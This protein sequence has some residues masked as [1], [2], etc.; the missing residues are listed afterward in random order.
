M[1]F[2]DTMSYLVKRWR[3]LQ[4]WHP[5][6]TTTQLKIYADA[7]T[8]FGGQGKLWGFIDGTF[9]GFC[10]PA[11]GQRDYY[12]GHKKAHGI[13]WQ[14][15]VTPDGIAS[16]AGPFL[17]KD[18][19]STMVGTSGLTRHLAHLWDPVELEEILFLFGDQAYSAHTYIKA[20]WPETAILPHRKQFNRS[21]QAARISVENL[22][23]LCAS[24]W[25][26]NAFKWNLRMGNMAV[27][28]YW[29]VAV[30]LTNCCTCLQGSNQI[31]SQFGVAPPSIDEYLLADSDAGAGF[32][33]KTA[34][35]TV[36]NS[37]P[38]SDSEEE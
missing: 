10:R 18:N 6:M 8:E 32:I 5:R 22:F 16:I 23:G 9:R 1:V 17:G 33:G 28:N 7:I 29:Q 19:D 13:K 38:N 24:R 26:A 34:P 35:N 30:L 2:N 20:P 3:K 27:A 11:Y 15:I 31:S 14:A 37:S 12:S 4:E 36:P 25:T 21:I